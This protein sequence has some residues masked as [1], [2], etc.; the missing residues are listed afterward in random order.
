V[1]RLLLAALASCALAFVAGAQAPPGAPFAELPI[2]LTSIG[3]SPDGEMV[4]VILERVGLAYQYDI[5]VT[6]GDLKGKGTLVVAIGGS[7]K[8]LGAA[9]IRIEDELKRSEALL[10]RARQLGMSIIG[11]HIGGEGRRGEL[12]DRIIRSVASECDYVIVVADGDKDKLFESLADKSRK[13]LEVV[14]R[15][16]RVA[17]PLKRAFK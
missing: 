7:S 11:L 2:L 9:G 12:S 3:Q 14:D 6:A 8:G 4:K 13:P 1:K 17:D 16:S 15:I 5:K 10:K